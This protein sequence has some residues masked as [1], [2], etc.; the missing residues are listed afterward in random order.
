M[1]KKGAEEWERKVVIAEVTQRSWII[2]VLKRMQEA[3]EGKVRLLRGWYFF[4]FSA[5]L[6]VDP[7]LVN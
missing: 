2:R 3:V 5:I 4:A 1:Q 6:P 7:G